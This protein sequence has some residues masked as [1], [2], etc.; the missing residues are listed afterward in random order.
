[1][2]KR[3]LLIV[4]SGPSGV[5]KGTILK[6]YLAG[7]RDTVFSISA[8]TR[9]PRVGEIDGT[10]YY[11][12]SQDEFDRL[13]ASDGLLEHAEFAGHCYGTPKKPVEDNLKN[14]IDVILEIEV[15]GAMQ[16]KKKFPGS[17]MVFVVPPSFAELRRRLLGRGTEEPSAVSQR[18]SNCAREIKA[19][20][21]YDY[22]IINNTV[23]D[24]LAQLE[25]IVD[26]QRHT[27]N[28]LREFLEEVEYDA[29][30]CC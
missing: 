19:A 1:M 13:V 18:L 15:Q 29:E 21:L 20:K 23:D 22:I 11:F 28:Y 17:L 4:V 25:T 14:G 12:V 10:H 16:V 27:A 8:T 6:K 5:G 24:A 26:A 9:A 30:T 3:G 2:N 7:H